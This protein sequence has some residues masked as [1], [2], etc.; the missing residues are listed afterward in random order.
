MNKAPFG[1]F[2]DVQHQFDDEREIW[3]VVDGEGNSIAVCYLERHARMICE[4]L[5]VALERA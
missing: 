1:Y 4:G 5:N 2:Q 3:V